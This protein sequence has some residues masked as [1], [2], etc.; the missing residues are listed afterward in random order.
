MKSKRVSRI[1][2]E[3]DAFKECRNFNRG[4]GKADFTGRIGIFRVICKRPLE[5]R[6]DFEYQIIR[7]GKPQTYAAGAFGI[8]LEQEYIQ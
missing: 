8:R 1:D 5:S 6:Y 4:Y 3:I 2:L 7:N